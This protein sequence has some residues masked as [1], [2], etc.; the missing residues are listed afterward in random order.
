MFAVC[1]ETADEV[2]IVSFGQLRS[3]VPSMDKYI[4]PLG[5]MERFLDSRG[6]VSVDLV[7]SFIEL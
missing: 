1:V 6:L 2:L 5:M 7:S 3:L 4:H